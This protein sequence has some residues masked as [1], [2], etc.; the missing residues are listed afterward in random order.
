MA[1]DSVTQAA[2]IDASPCQNRPFVHRRVRLLNVSKSSSGEL[3][4][5]ALRWPVWVAAGIAAVAAVLAVWW[6]GGFAAAPPPSLPA[7]EAGKGLDTGQ[8]HVV[9][10]GATLSAKRPDGRPAAPGK[11]SLAIELELTNRTKASSNDIATAIRP[12]LAA[13][14]PKTLPTTQVLRRDN[15]V[16]S[17][18]HPKMPERIALAWDIP[19]AS[20][21]P[22][23]LPVVVMSKLHKRRD[24][25]LGA[26]GWFDPKP[27]AEVHLSVTTPDAPAVLP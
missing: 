20:K 22:E 10:L 3:A 6:S 16:L 13:I 26:S 12:M 8:W 7:L 18:L 2:A 17:S 24:N 25:L 19:L 21:I 4:S 14:P 23:P 11:A 15:S 5:K 1:A 9:V 27:M